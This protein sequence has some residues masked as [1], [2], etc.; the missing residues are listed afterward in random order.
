[1]DARD[2]TGAECLVVTGIHPWND[3]YAITLFI[4]AHTHL[5]R[6]VEQSWTFEGVQQFSTILYEPQSGA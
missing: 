1:V 5:L 3:E 6:R 4:D 2:A